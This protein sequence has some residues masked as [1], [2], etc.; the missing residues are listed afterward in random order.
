M[1]YDYKNID[2]VLEP[3]QNSL[4]WA[5]E[6]YSLSQHFTLEKF[7][8][9]NI[10]DTLISYRNYIIIIIL[11]LF[12]ILKIKKTK[13][14][15][16]SSFIFF[17]I[18]VIFLLFSIRSGFLRYGIYTMPLFYLLCSFL[19]SLEKNEFKFNILIS[20]FIIN[21]FLNFSFLNSKYKSQNN[22]SNIIQIHK[23]CYN[24]DN[25]K[26]YNYLNYFFNEDKK[27]LKIICNSLN[28]FLKQFKTKELTVNFE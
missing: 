25:Q 11:N 22:L 6:K 27:N 20:L 26:E 3:I 28:R 18:L 15:I 21:T 14:Q 4:R 19:L 5:Q 7:K 9:I 10:F 17:S 2:V 13:I 23:S 16:I 24:L 12:L 1:N 8:S